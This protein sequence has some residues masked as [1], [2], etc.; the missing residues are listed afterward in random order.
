MKIKDI[1]F[2]S[3]TFCTVVMFVVFSFQ[4]T[5]YSVSTKWEDAKISM[6]DL[7]NS[8]W[9]L[10]AHSSNR[11]ATA[12]SPGVSSYEEIMHTFIL[13]KNSKY[14]MCFVENPRP[15]IANAASCRKLN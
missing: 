13:A 5:A 12:A 11:A 9:Q 14:I 4:S 10:T 6:N 1:F 7:L 2:K 3:A 15:P 8:G